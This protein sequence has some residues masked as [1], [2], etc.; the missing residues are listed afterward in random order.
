[1]GTLIRAA[2]QD[3]GMSM[4]RLAAAAGVP[5]ADLRRFEECAA[6][7]APA[8]LE[9]ILSAAQLRPSIPLALEARAVAELA[10]QHHLLDVRVF[11]SLVRGRDTAASDIDLLVTTTPETTLF[12]LGGFAHGVEERTGFPVDILTDDDLHQDPYFAHVLDEAVP[13]W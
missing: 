8:V 5:S 6:R 7:P 11:G 12:D 10:E 9:R 4:D 3:I 2:R 1:V 13:L